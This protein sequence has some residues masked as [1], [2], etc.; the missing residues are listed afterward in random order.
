MSNI[1]NINTDFYTTQVPQESMSRYSAAP[2]SIPKY[3][4]NQA[5]KEK[6]EF[7]KMVGKS[8]REQKESKENSRVLSKVLALCAAIGAFVILDHKKII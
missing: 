8:Y 6:D 3:S 1:S 4:I 7:R 2:V 5:F